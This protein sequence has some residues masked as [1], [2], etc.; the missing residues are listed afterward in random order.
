MLELKTTASISNNCSNYHSVNVPH[1]NININDI[2]SFATANN[3]S[4]NKKMGGKIRL[5]AFCKLIK[6]E[7]LNKIC[8]I[9]ESFTPG[10]FEDDDLSMRIIESGYKLMLFNDSFIHHFGSVTFNKDNIKFKN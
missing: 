7:V 2:I 3:G 8:I 6:R 5:V 4:N 9:D 1:I 10:N